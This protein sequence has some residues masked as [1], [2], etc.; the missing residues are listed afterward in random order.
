MKPEQQAAA[1]SDA[2][3]EKT[4][5]AQIDDRAHF[6]PPWARVPAAR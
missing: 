5:P 6:A 2:C 3:F 1:R 4:P